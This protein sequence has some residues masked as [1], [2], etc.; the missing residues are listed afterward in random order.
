MGGGLGM[1]TPNAKPHA[2]SAARPSSTATSSAQRFELTR[3]VNVRAIH[4]LANTA[5]SEKE[6]EALYG[7]CY[8]QHGHDYKVQVTL[9]GQLE[10]RTGMVFDRDRFDR[11]LR[12]SVVE[13]LDGA[14]LNEIFPNTACEALARAL[15]LRLKPLFPDGMLTRVSIQETR[16]NYFE[17]PPAEAGT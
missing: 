10:T 2:D 3:E 9:S 5:L 4:N 6:N 8:R 7:P 1:S 17:F 15:F 13:P 12:K 11:I 16:K 14:D